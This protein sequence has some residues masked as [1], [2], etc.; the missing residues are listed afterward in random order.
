MP[1]R[2]TQASRVGEGCGEAAWRQAFSARLTHHEHWPLA[3]SE[4]VQH[5]HYMRVRG[6]CMAPAKCNLALH[7]VCRHS[8]SSVHDLQGWITDAFAKSV[9]D[10]PPLLSSGLL[11]SWS[12]TR[13]ALGQR[14]V[15]WSSF[16]RLVYRFAS[17]RIFSIC[18]V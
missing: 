1:G 9:H 10:Q 17:F 3:V 16:L 13:P 6:G 18:G 2:C 8:V 5:A 15:A 12:Q 11:G 14:A 4:A 7:D